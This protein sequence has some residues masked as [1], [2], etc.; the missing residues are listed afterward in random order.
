MKN[1]RYLPGFKKKPS[2]FKEILYFFGIYLL[3]IAV[4]MG[5]NTYLKSIDS[6]QKT[7][8]WQPDDPIARLAIQSNALSTNM[9]ALTKERDTLILKVRQQEETINR[10]E[11][12]IP[13]KKIK[14]IA[15]NLG[16]LM[17]G[18]STYL[19]D[20]CVEY[21]VD[22][23]L[24]AAIIKHESAN[25]TSRAIRKQN[26]IAGFM[27]DNGLM[28]FKSIRSSIDFMVD[29]LKTHYLDK[30]FNSI[31]KIQKK[32]CPIGAK[33]DPKGLNKYWLPSVKYYYEI[34]VKESI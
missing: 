15:H 18:N 33:N 28:D 1:N 5:G 25:G 20:K 12:P 34:M 30:G 19:Y 9:D 21:N 26:N 29:L 11:K 22:P 32:Y 3:I 8:F 14:T 2:R 27:G 31:E 17:M 16:G 23:L 6:L 24:A 7:L 10:P 13:N 4:G